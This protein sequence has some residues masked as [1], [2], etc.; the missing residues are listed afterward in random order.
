[1]EEKKQTLLSI[2][3]TNKTRA[4]PEVVETTG[5][6]RDYVYWG[7]D[8][9]FPQFVDYLYNECST[10][11]SIIDGTAEY[12]QGNGVLATEKWAT[13]NKQG[14]TIED[15]VLQ[16]AT[17]LMLFNGFAIQV[18]YS[19]ANTTVELYALDFK[20]IRVSPDKKKVFY[21]KNWSTYTSKFEEYDAYDPGRINPEKRT[22]IYVYKG[23]A[24]TYYP[25]PSWRGAFRDC[26]SEIASSKYVLTTLGNGLNVK[27]IIT[28]P[29]NDGQLTPEEKRE[30]EKSIKAK[31]TGPDAESAFMLFWQE[32]GMGEVKIDSIKSED[33]TDRF[34]AIK[35][36]AR[37]NIFVAF[38][39]APLLFGLTSEMTTG[40]STNEFRD[41]FGL[42]NRTV[43]RPK[44]AK[45][46]DVLQKLTGDYS[47]QIIP[48]KLETEE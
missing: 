32:E 23:A 35:K 22:Q 37:E 1:M 2:V 21:A 5:S 11:R 20:R 42:Y 34:N 47:I 8:N 12:I 25:Y 24:R 15:F 14:T 17:D 4:L 6:S 36:A 18:V 19:L 40:F 43:V 13:V 48:F 45:I 39:A 33:E 10:L 31:F 41:Q 30:V 29:N 9:N 27:S 44:Q 3:D 26:L 28:L 38:R 46:L 16:L 7:K